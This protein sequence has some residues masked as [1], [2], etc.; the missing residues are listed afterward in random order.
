MQGLLVRAPLV[1]Q[2][3]EHPH[4]TLPA[5][6]LQ[7]V[8]LSHVALLHKLPSNTSVFEAKVPCGEPNRVV[9]RRVR[10]PAVVY[11]FHL[12]RSPPPHEENSQPSPSF[13]SAMARRRLARALLLFG[14]LSVG[15]CI[16]PSGG[17]AAPPQ[18]ARG[19]RDARQVKY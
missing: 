14:C 12:Q 1:G 19:R 18:L 17:R 8:A 13:C 11:L 9:A 10:S 15:S 6:Q 7:V 5:E 2:K 4:R 16:T 3:L